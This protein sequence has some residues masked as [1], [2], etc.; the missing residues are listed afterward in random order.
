[1]PVFH[2]LK[3]PIKLNM[4]VSKHGVEVIAALPAVEFELNMLFYNAGTLCDLTRAG[5]ALGL[6]QGGRAALLA[7]QLKLAEV[8]I[9]GVAESRLPKGIRTTADFLVY[10]SGPDE[11]G[12]FGCEAWLATRAPYFVK[13][14]TAFR[15]TT[16][17]VA[18]VESEPTLL[19][20]A[21]DAPFLRIDV[22]VAHAPHS[23]KS[24]EIIS[25]W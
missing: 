24:K 20:L 13:G 3:P 25:G 21:I 1:M 8:K 6:Q 9:A 18:V 7:A 4:D 23:G 12:N 11:A 10:A 15:F 5:R 16:E 22:V 17:H 14:T 19:L 2:V